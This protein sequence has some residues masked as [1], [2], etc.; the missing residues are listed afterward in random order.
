MSQRMY[1]LIRWWGGV[2]A[3]IIRK[4]FSDEIINKLLKIQWWQYNPELFE[5][6]EIAKIEDAIVELERRIYY[7][8][9]KYECEKYCFI[10]KENKVQ[11]LN[12]NGE[13]IEERIV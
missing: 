1:I 6:I 12:F 10:H 11:H 8:V 7:G 2:P 9:E 4:R 13:I 5:G 3:R